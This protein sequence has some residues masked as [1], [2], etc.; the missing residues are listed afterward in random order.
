MPFYIGTVV[1]FIAI[2][3]FNWTVFIII[4]SSLICKKSIKTQK[5]KKTISN[6]KQQLIIA[7]TLSSLFG[8]G[9]GIGLLATQDIYSNKTV[10]DTVAALFILATT[11]HGVLIFIMHCLRSEKIKNVWKKWFFDVTGREFGMRSHESNRASLSG[12]KL[13]SV[14][15]NDTKQHRVDEYELAV[16]LQSLRSVKDCE[17][18][19]AMPVAEK[20]VK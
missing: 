7:M 19:F 8:L 9:W 12:N 20:E 15:V 14:S 17:T 3:I 13:R 11:F 1:P 4:T 18:S 5:D 16:A 10:H 2:Y 6:F